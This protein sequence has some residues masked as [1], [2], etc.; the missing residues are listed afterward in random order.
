MSV[1]EIAEMTNL[2]VSKIEEIKK[3]TGNTISLDTP[4]GEDKE[5]LLIDYIKDE[6]F[7]EDDLLTTSVRRKVLEVVNECHLTD[8][9]KDVVLRRFGFNDDFHPETLQD[10]AKDY[11][12]TRERIRQIEAKALRKLRAPSN[13]KKLKDLL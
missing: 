12:V 13:S 11:N 9:E 1:E 5:S 6:S 2:P 8:R 7:S 4:V 10:I 3:F